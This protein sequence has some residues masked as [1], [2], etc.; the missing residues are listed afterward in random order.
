MTSLSNKHPFVRRSARQGF[1]LIELAMTMVIVG[2]MASIG[3][4]ALKDSMASGDASLINS[5]RSA[6]E[7]VVAQ[8][9]ERLEVDVITASQASA[10]AGPTSGNGSAV[11]NGVLRQLGACSSS[12]NCTLT[13]SGPTFILRVNNSYANFKV[14]TTGKVTITSISGDV[15]S[16][17]YSVNGD[18]I[19]TR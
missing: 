2:T 15:S 3:T 1:T 8:G 4:I 7:S 10:S 6:F 14:E 16:A 19:L 9:A 5:A 17:G 13:G 12:N 11:K 18:N